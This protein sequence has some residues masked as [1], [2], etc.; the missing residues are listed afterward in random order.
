MDIAPCH[1][2]AYNDLCA[3]ID[4]NSIRMQEGDACYQILVSKLPIKDGARVWQ[5]QIKWKERKKAYR[6]GGIL[7]SHK[8]MFRLWG[9]FLQREEIQLPTPGENLKRVTVG[10][11]STDTEGRQKLMIIAHQGDAIKI[12]HYFRWKNCREIFDTTTSQLR[13]LLYRGM[14]DNHVSVLRWKEQ[15][16]YDLEVKKACRT[17]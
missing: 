17:I 1:R 9:G 16:Q 3:A 4:T 8:R 11:P 5:F 7:A 13:L 2:R 6:F 10:L 15:F 14:L 12:T